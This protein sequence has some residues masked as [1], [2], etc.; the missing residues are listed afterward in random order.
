[1]KPLPESIRVETQLKKSL[2]DDMTLGEARGFFHNSDLVQKFLRH[3]KHARI[4]FVLATVPES[5]CPDTMELRVFR[6]LAA[7]GDAF[8]S[9]DDGEGGPRTKVIPKVLV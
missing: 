8:I 9:V 4:R 3:M 1:M 2:P 6:A 5:E 7:S